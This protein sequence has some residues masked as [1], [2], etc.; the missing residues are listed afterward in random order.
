MIGL[1]LLPFSNLCSLALGCK[2]WRS[3]ASDPGLRVNGLKV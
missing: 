2:R 3:V 1:T